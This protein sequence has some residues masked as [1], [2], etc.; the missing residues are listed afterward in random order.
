MSTALADEVEVFSWSAGILKLMPWAL[1]SS[2][3]RDDQRGTCAA[4]GREGT[5]FWLDDGF[6][7][8]RLCTRDF[9]GEGCK[10]TRRI[11]SRNSTRVQ[12]DEAA[13]SLATAV[14]PEI[15]PATDLKRAL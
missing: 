4:S 10:P 12:S 13:P 2:W 15:D 3:R 9:S 7:G 11:S 6:G 14:V 1:G 8:R 5:D